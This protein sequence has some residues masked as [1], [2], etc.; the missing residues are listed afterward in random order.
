M[1]PSIT[2]AGRKTCRRPLGGLRGRAGLRR[3]GGLRRGGLIVALLPLAAATWTTPA[4]LAG[5]DSDI[6][7]E[8]YVSDGLP[9]R[10]S[11]AEPADRG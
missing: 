11:L 3:R 9:A 5:V 2:A 4:V 7:F 8:N 6:T 1:D 10:A